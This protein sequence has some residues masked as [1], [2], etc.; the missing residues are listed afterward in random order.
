MGTYTYISIMYPKWHIANHSQWKLT[1]CKSEPVTI[2][3]F[4]CNMRFFHL[5][6]SDG[7]S[8]CKLSSDSIHPKKSTRVLMGL[9]MHDVIKDIKSIKTKA[10]TRLY[11]VSWASVIWLHI[12]SSTKL[13]RRIANFMGWLKLKMKPCNIHRKATNT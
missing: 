1:Y 8:I 12:S 7:G 11:L 9:N 4:A 10:N 6:W 2:K 13:T 3:H 5:W